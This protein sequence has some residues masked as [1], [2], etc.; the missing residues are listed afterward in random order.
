MV[1]RSPTS[2]KLH[3]LHTWVSLAIFEV[4]MYL[5]DSVGRFGVESRNFDTAD[6]FK[7]CNRCVRQGLNK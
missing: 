1:N 3:N 4:H 5:P 6:T 2:L 7:I